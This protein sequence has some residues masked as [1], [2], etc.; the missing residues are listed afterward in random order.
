MNFAIYIYLLYCSGVE[1][2]L[3]FFL[4]IILDEL[5]LQVQELR[6]FLPAIQDKLKEDLGIKLK[7]LT[8]HLND[9]LEVIKRV[10]LFSWNRL[11]RCQC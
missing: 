5:E 9:I 11:K 8:C 10:S 2:K 3:Q 4:L 7:E 1:Q 6:T